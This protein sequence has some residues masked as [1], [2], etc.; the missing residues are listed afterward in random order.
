MYTL[1]R[2][3][4]LSCSPKRP[5]SRPKTNFFILVL[6]IWNEAGHQWFTPVTLATWEVEIERIRVQGQPGKKVGET[7]FQ[8]TARCDGP[9]LSSQATFEAEIR[10][11]V[12]GQR[13]QKKVCKVPPQW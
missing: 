8:T 6:K 12:P 10:I 7:Q 11:A 3:G 5:S 2:I 13:K 4:L 9:Y 1:L